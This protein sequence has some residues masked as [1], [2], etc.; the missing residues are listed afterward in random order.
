MCAAHGGQLAEGEDLLPK[1]LRVRLP[2]AAPPLL[3]AL[4]R[5]D[6]A[7]PSRT[8][9]HLAARHALE[10]ANRAARRVRRRVLRALLEPGA[11]AL[12]DRGVL[13]ELRDAAPPRLLHYT[14]VLQLRRLHE[15]LHQPGTV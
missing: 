11:G 8:R 12:R 3:R 7:P 9:G 1:L 14:S 13:H 2:R 10:A 15:Q 6:L 5:D 4:R